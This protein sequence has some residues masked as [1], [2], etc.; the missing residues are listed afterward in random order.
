MGAGLDTP[1]DKQFGTGRHT[2]FNVTEPSAVV[3]GW[4]ILI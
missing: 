3:N 2:I 4:Q 1:K